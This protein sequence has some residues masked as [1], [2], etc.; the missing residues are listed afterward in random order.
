MSKQFVQGDV[1]FILLSEK[2]IMK[3]YK[4][5]SPQAGR[6]V[7]ARGEKTGHVHTVDSAAATLFSFAFNDER[8]IVV[9]METEVEHDEH[10]PLTL[11]PGAYN[12]VLQRQYVEKEKARRVLD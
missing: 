8:I 10:P 12:I 3:N 11:S 9:D 5:I 1:M 6:I 2:P 7:I 4:P